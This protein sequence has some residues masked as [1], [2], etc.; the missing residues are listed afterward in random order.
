MSEIPSTALLPERLTYFYKGNLR[1][2]M[3]IDDSVQGY[4][5]LQ[6]INSLHSQR[7]MQSLVQ[8]KS[9]LRGNFK[10][11]IVLTLCQE[12]LLAQRD[13]FTKKMKERLIFPNFNFNLILSYT[14]FS[15]NSTV[16][17]SQTFLKHCHLTNS[18]LPLWK[19]KTLPKFMSKN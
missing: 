15:Q 16:K 2:D 7:K 1:D 8:N 10:R 5:F 19:M 4:L 18:T 17:L 9:T 13:S 6:E 11:V 3:V 14:F 12:T